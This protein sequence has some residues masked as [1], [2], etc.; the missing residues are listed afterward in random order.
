M[1]VRFSLVT[2]VAAALCTASLPSQAMNLAGV[3]SFRLDN[4]LEV[5]VIPDRRTS[6]VTHMIW[7]KAGSADDPTGKSGLAHFLEHLM[8]KGTLAHPG[9]RFSKF[10]AAQGGQD[11]AFTTPDYT[12]YF[13]R[14]G[15]EHLQTVMAFE[16]DRM[17]NLSL[18]DEAIAVERDIVLEEYN[19]RIGNSPASRLGE[20]LRA[21]LYGNRSYGRPVIGWPQ[22]IAAL[23]RDDV[24]AFYRRFY[25]PNNAVLIVAGN[26]SPDEVRR[27]A[28]GT[29]GLIEARGD[30]RARQRELPAAPTE[31]VDVAI[32]DS[33]AQPFLRRS[34]IVPSHANAEPGVA[35]A[36]E[37]LAHIFSSGP[38]SRFNRAVV[39]DAR[40]AT[41]AGGS[42][43]GAALGW[44]RF[45]IYA[46]A[47]PGIDF[48]EI[49][50][51]FDGTLDDIVVNGVAGDELERA[52]TRLIA[53]VLYARDSQVTL[54]RSYGV[55]L[56]TGTSVAHLQSWP[57]RIRAVT[58]QDVRQAV[59]IWLDKSRA[60]SGYLLTDTQASARDNGRGRP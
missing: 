55:A 49:E 26:V 32:T 52:K 10:V 54:A 42:Y 28:E 15:R 47:E 30:A 6:T 3:A 24:L 37:V 50:S 31:L 35:E 23:D 2:M 43:E 17:S 41:W 9:G 27:A 19:T 46:Y 22:D 1:V 18:T 53:D 12:A 4:G 33:R 21:R 11:N 25:A 48:A 16:A 29:Y 7:Y 40:A 59:R 14:I 8:F 45:D 5:V 57:E 34:Y 13:Q 60:L 44:S 38:T 58:S 20:Q 56:T 51:L 39:H 36:L